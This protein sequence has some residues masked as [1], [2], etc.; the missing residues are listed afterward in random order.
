MA[1]GNCNTHNIVPT[2]TAAA[3]LNTASVATIAA[4]K[5]GADLTKAAWSDLNSIPSELTCSNCKV[6][7]LVPPTIFDWKCSACDTTM[8][9]T[10]AAPAE[11]GKAQSA[12]RLA[13]PE[14]CTACQAA[15][16]TAAPVLTCGAC[17]QG[18]SVPRSNARKHTDKGVALVKKA[19]VRIRDEYKQ[20]A[21]APSEF[22]CEHCNT[23]L[24]IE[25]TQDAADPEGKQGSGDIKLGC[26]VCQK[27]TS[28]PRSNFQNAFR[29]HTATV[30]RAA[31][32]VY[33]TVSKKPSVLCS[34]C[35]TTVALPIGETD[36]KTT[37]S[38]DAG[39]GAPPP[40][41]EDL[42]ASKPSA[43]EVQCPKCGT[44][45]QAFS[46]LAV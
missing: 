10:T 7:M 9:S 14:T 18:N 6:Q 4:A 25:N 17:G 16:P 34:T 29:R 19:G 43:V 38:A 35:N 33:Y 5:Q 32:K 24:F 44:L 27:V 20:L 13:P 8:T 37:E 12:A 39:V 11:E 46:E 41:T 31:T 26:G 36:Q 40:Y 15:A 1:C 28:V 30:S 42:D 2:S 3:A 23:A 22:N 21:S 45:L